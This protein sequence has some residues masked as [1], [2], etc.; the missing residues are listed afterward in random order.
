MKPTMLASPSP[1][2]WL[3]L[4]LLILFPGASPLAADTVLVVPFE[5]SAQAADLDWVGESF[6][7]ALSGRLAAA[8][9]D[10]VTRD[11]RLAALERLGLPAT[12]PLTQSSLL[13]LG[14]EVGAD[15]VVLGRFEVRDDRL[16][17][18]T[19]SLNLHRPALSPWMGDSGPF[20][21][22]LDL[23]QELAWRIL[24]QLD[25]A[26]SL[27]RE[28]FR[29]R[30]PRL[31]VSA[32]ESYVRGLVA[33]SREQQRRYFLQAVRLE[34]AYTPPAFRLAQ[35]AYE[36][37]DY[38]TAATWFGKIPLHDA[39]GPE[40]RFYLALCHFMQ[41]DY[42]GAADTMAALAERLPAPAVWNNL[43]VFASRRGQP[44]GA[45][46][47]FARVLQRNPADADAYFNLGLHHLRQAKWEAAAQA[48][49]QCLALNPGDSEARLLYAHALERLGQTE[50]AERERQQA[51]NGENAPALDLAEDGFEFDR[52]H[53]H[54][55]P[56]KRGEEVSGRESAR[57]RHV[58]VHIE[59][60]R[61]LLT[62]GEVEQ[63][64]QEFTEAVLLDP[65]SH[66]GHFFL[67]EVYRRHGHLEAAVSELKA[68]LWSQETVEARLRLAELYLAQQ[69]PQQA[70]EQVQ[71][72]L[73]LDPSNTQARALEARLPIEAADSP[74][75]DGTVQ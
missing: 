66:R 67:A 27:S 11:E 62:R 75:E 5:N 55:T 17:A 16:T 61:D 7:E 33:M 34:P 49:T 53:L 46:G 25:P 41:D 64:Q 13:R 47:Y 2:R 40:A 50:A 37:E 54:F 8:G 3:C 32:F 35:L 69:D 51:G 6:A 63:A 4:G 38:A 24:G 65:A 20:A 71:A 72:A 19:R 43:A 42:D 44:E 12:L 48:L 36:A 23:Q 60:G 15:W 56:T 73:A 70:R 57:A 26:R 21:G 74:A 30:V 22:L 31:D 1:L 39:L 45:A 58:A 52:L 68:S 59:R 29:Q 14:E 9:Q 18:W 28:G 10:M